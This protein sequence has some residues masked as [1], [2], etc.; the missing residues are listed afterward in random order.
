MA[1]QAPIRTADIISPISF[2]AHI[3]YTDVHYINVASDISALQYLDRNQIRDA[4]LNPNADAVCQMHLALPLMG[5]I[6]D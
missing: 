1:L 2:D 4:A 5:G 6:N 3:N